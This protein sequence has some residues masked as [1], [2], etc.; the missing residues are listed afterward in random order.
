MDKCERPI[1]I[2]M[3]A[4]G[5]QGGGVLTGWLVDTAEANGYMAQ[6]TYVAGVAQ[7]TGATVYCVEMFPRESARI[8]GQLPVFTPYP[9]PGDVELVIAGEMAETGRAIEKGF[10]T[11]NATTLLASSHRVYS[12][13][14]KEALGDGIV[15]M[16]KVRDIARKAA[17]QFVCFDMQQAADDTGSIISS[18]LL[19][20]IAASGA[21]PFDRA[22]FE[23]TIRN[24]GKA[25]DANLRG[26]AAGYDGT[27]NAPEVVETPVAA[28]VPQGPNGEALAARI[29][30]ELPGPVRDIALHGALRTLDYQDVRYANEYLDLL[31]GFADVD[32]DS[33]R[34]ELTSEVA[35]QLALQMCYEDTIRVADLKTRSERFARIRQH[36]GAT[37]DQPV[38][39]VEY[40][41][42]RIEEICDTLPSFL[43]AKIMNSGILNKL[44][45]PM[46][47]KGRNIS[48]T[49]ISG[50]LLFHLLSKCRTIR[51]ATYRY[52]KQKSFID[53]W[54][55]R[56]TVAACDDYEYG[57][58]IARCIEIVKGYG[59][60]YERGRNRYLAIVD[61][62]KG[63][64]NAD[65]VRQLHRA[66]LADENG[67]LFA[68]TLASMGSGL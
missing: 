56:V 63:A 59:E 60:T 36:V 24:T 25:V 18:V 55:G 58:A 37:D 43:G 65:T 50:F 12:M 31:A 11:P 10:V 3:L 16:Q 9:I 44:L 42:P 40:L 30:A 62:E 1:S 22:A 38:R 67:E 68:E 57:L 6:S 15:D 27:G 53:D 47:R 21:L 64:K 34:H 19:G 49:G 4:L 32:A 23:E 41:H 51:R 54:L 14:E 8:A 26:F 20:A 13:P 33:R 39:V 28:A 52:K 46:V 35:R 66:V 5:G 7:R 17:K 45:A 2:A 48:T 29:E 61:P